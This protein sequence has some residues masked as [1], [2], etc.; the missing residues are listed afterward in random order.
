MHRGEFQRFLGTR[1]LHLHASGFVL[2]IVTVINVAEVAL[3]KKSQDLEENILPPGTFLMQIAIDYSRPA[4][5]QK[6]DL[7]WQNN[8]TPMAKK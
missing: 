6:A 1:N 7:F 4:Q 3:R 2:V 8:V 5:P